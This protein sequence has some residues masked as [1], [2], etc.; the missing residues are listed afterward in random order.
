MAE[1]PQ[2]GDPPSGDLTIHIRELCLL[3]RVTTVYYYFEAKEGK[4][5]KP[6]R[7]RIPLREALAWL[8]K[9][10]EKYADRA[11][12]V[13][14]LRSRRSAETLAAVGTEEGT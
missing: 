11:A 1:L 10:A 8:Q 14:R 4:A 7:G 12:A 2:P 3:A 13:E 5:P 6:R 9:R